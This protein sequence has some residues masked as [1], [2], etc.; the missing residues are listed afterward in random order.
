M[1]TRSILYLLVIGIVAGISAL[2]GTMAGGVFVFSYLQSVEATP[3]NTIPPTPTQQV[4][5]DISTS[6]LETSIIDA[7]ETVAPTVVT[8]VGEISGRPVS[9]SGVV[10]SSQGYILTNNHVVEGTS[11]VA[12]ILADGVE[13]PAQIVGTDMYAD[14]A[15]LLA[16]GEFPAVAGLGNSDDLKPGETVIAIGSPLGDFVNTVT[17]GVI[18]ATGRSLDTGNGFL[19]EDL[20]QTDAAINQGNSGGPLVNLAGDVIGINTLVVRGSGRSNTIAEGLGFAIPINTARIVAEQILDKGYFARPH[21]G[22]RWQ[23]ISPRIAQAYNLP[24]QWGAYISDVNPGS[25]AAM[26]GLNEGDIITHIADVPLD[27]DHTYINTLF[28]HEPGEEVSI[29]VVRNRQELT[30]SLILGESR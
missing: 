24:V 14:L 19:M 8:V 22:I 27:E 7:V 20:I 3:T 11:M 26:S 21:L 4:N 15:I 10:I 6:S 16:N 18:S 25:P 12:V 5:L 28:T 30:V 17:V 1:S 13:L 29:Q 9:G 23:S 2:I